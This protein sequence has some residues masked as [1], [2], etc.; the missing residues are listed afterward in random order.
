MI[1]A[2]FFKANGYA[3]QNKECCRKISVENQIYRANKVCK[4]IDVASTFSNALEID[5]AKHKI[6]KW[7]AIP[8]RQ[9]IKLE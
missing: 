5:L 9:E 7:D 1:L 3:L 2:W 8:H 6:G 4:L